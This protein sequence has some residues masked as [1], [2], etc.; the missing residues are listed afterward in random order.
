[1]PLGSGYAPHLRFDGAREALAVRVNDVPADARFGQTITVS[2]ELSYH[3][4]MNYGTLA[5]GV[6]FE[7]LEGQKV[8]AEGRCS[9]S[10]TRLEA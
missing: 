8:V 4:Q 10:V 2:I 3:P 6:R 9:S 1:M 7:L 5:P